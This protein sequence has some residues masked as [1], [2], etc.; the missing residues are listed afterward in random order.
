MPSAG[1]DKA[2]EAPLGVGGQVTAPGW[3]APAWGLDKT[4]GHPRR[5]GR[6][7]QG[8][9]G[10]RTSLLPPPL[11]KTI[12][13]RLCEGWV[14]AERFGNVAGGTMRKSR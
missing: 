10:N 5:T 4:P 14:V 11:D 9:E 13:H 6:P 1:L 7:G 12:G 3:M 2:S 8:L